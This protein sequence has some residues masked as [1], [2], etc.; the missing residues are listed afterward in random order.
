MRPAWWSRR[1]DHVPFCLDGVPY[2]FFW[3]PDRECY[4][5]ACDTVDRIDPDGHLAVSLLSG[6]VVRAAADSPLALAELV[7]PG[8]DV[9]RKLPRAKE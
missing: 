5:Q 3:T 7:E 2:V 6:D 8:T 9:C 4:H 1:S